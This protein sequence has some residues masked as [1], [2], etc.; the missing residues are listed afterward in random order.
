[1]GCQSL[2]I[3]FSCINIVGE[4]RYKLEEYS[5]SLGGVVDKG[6]IVLRG[7]IA[8]TSTPT[9]RSECIRNRNNKAFPLFRMDT[10]SKDMVL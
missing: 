7:M 2:P 1:M 8:E 4:S 5:W 10:S 6:M 3:L 9:S